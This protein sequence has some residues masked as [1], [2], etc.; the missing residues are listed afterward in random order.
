MKVLQINCMYP[1]GSTGKLTQDIHHYLQSQGIASRVC[2]GRGKRSR[3]PGTV[4]LCPEWYAKANNLLS[5]FRGLMY[6]GCLLSTLRLIRY[7]R[8]EKPDV[9]HLQCINGYF[10]NIYRL[11]SWLKRS[12]VPTVLT[13]HAE[14]PYTA[15]CAH[16]LG[17]E[18]WRTGCGHC[19]RLRQETLSFFRDGTARS[20]QRMHGA[21]R[22]FGRELAVVSVSRW[23]SR[24]AAQSPILGDMPHR[25]ILNGVDTDIFHFRPREAEDKRL[26]V[27]HATP[28]FSDDPE[29]GKGGWHLLELAKRLQDLPVQF[30]VAGKYRVRG[31]VP[32][33][34]T[35]LGQID[36]RC[37]LAELYSGARLTL[38]T[39]RRETFSMVCAESLCCGTPVVGFAAGGPEEICLP[40]YSRFVPWGNLDALEAAVRQELTV[41]RNKP[42]LS[43]LACRHYDRG[44]MLREYAA[45]Y[46][47][48][49]HEDAQ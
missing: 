15:N 2:Y 37:R 9:V 48:L 4:K 43:Q 6:G 27:F 8:R 29:H 5:R 22:G 7:I 20:F 16:A 42:E 31:A 10:V 39:S 46:R 41:K 36:D 26:L 11:V 35:L 33:N 30:L 44:R 32:P 47:E 38:L 45:L 49:A 12:R 23:L 1:D 17:C 13:L 18:K 25:T 28:M 21:F 24:R 14:F 34:V 40:N 19:P 3:E